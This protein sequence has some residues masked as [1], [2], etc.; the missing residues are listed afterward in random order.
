L[1]AGSVYFLSRPVSA[2]MELDMA[3]K[4]KKLGYR[5]VYE[6]EAVVD[7]LSDRKPSRPL[8][9]LSE[10]PHAGALRSA[11]LH[12]ATFWPTHLQRLKT[13][14]YGRALANSGI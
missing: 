13:C 8:V 10:S 6:P 14:V 11:E 3:L 2:R 7:H 1:I 12:L 5:I 9:H 4:I